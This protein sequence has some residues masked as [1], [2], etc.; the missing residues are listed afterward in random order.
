M[1]DA[2]RGVVWYRTNILLLSFS[3]ASIGPHSQVV[4]GV[5]GVEIEVAGFEVLRHDGGRDILG[6]Y[7]G[8]I[9]VGLHLVHTQGL[10]VYLLLN[11]QILDIYMAGTSQPLSVDY[12]QS[13]ARICE[14]D[15]FDHCPVIG[16]QGDDP[17]GLGCRL[18]E[19]IQLGLARR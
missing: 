1:N 13:G 19:R 7:V 2:R 9:A 15:A 18:G 16:E 12:A 8:N 3:V 14:D 4:G 5:L 6:Q 17:L 10:P 11:P